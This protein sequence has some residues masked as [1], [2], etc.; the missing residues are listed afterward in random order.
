MVLVINPYKP[1]EPLVVKS[2]GSI[3]LIP[4]SVAGHDPGALSD[5]PTFMAYL[6]DVNI[7]TSET[8]CFAFILFRM[9]SLLQRIFFEL[10]VFRR[11]KFN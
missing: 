9:E 2:E 11:R 1:N 10:F 7:Y 8:Y 3:L 5:T 6:N 4:K